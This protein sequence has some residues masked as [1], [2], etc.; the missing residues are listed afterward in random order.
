MRHIDVMFLWVQSDVQ[1]GRV[2]IH[3]RPIVD[4]FA[5]VL[6]KAVEEARMKRCSEGF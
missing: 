2:K 6:S 4:M 1:S 5:D 3:E